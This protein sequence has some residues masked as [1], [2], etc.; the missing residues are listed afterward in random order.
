[1]KSQT[2]TTT[3]CITAWFTGTFLFPPS[4]KYKE[5][6]PYTSDLFCLCC[7]LLF[8][9]ITHMDTC[10]LGRSP[11]Y[12]GSVHRRDLCI[13]TQPSQDTHIN[14]HGGTRIRNPSNWATTGLCYRPFGHWDR[15]KFYVPVLKNVLQL[16]HSLFTHLIRKVG[17]KT[18]FVLS[19]ISLYIQC[20]LLHTFSI[21][22]IDQNN[23]LPDQTQLIK[24][25]TKEPVFCL[26]API[27][28]VRLFHMSSNYPV[29][30]KTFLWGGED[31]FLNDNNNIYLLQSGCHPVAVVILH[32]YKIWNW[33][34]LNLSLE[35]YM[36]SM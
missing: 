36:R 11:L 21:F 4:F 6:V 9:L 31:D 27:L 10:T 30:D 23:M 26:I 17:K 22:I 29:N 28:L 1:M 15:C 34:L 24:F 33:L 3:N 20:V 35:C 2:L 8:N 32:V 12:E 25:I 7:G 13:H 18:D 14:S 5:G 16:I 19:C